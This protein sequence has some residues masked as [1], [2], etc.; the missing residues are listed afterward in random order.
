MVVVSREALNRAS[1][2]VIVVPLTSFRE[3]RL[4]PSDV[5]VRAG[6]A[7]LA[8]DSVVVGVQ[9]RVLSKLRLGQVLGRLGAAT[10]A[11]VEDALL[12]VLDLPGA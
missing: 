8:Q 4:Y 6:E 7:G 9:I 1:P 11:Q 12:Q 2:V 10:M 5:L 3:Q